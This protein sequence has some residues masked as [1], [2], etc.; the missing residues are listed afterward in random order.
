MLESDAYLEGLLKDR[1]FLLL[2]L[3]R[4]HFF[5]SILNA[6]VYGRGGV[7][8]N[9]VLLSDNGSTLNFVTES[10]AQHAGREKVGTW[11]GTIEQLKDEIQIEA[12]MYQIFFHLTAPF[13]K[14]T[15]VMA[16][17]TSAIGDRVPVDSGVMDVLCELLNIRKEFLAHREDHDDDESP[18]PRG[19][20]TPPA[21]R[22]LALQPPAPSNA[23]TPPAPAAT[24]TSSRMAG[25]SIP[26]S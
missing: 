26:P 14:V 20:R 4:R 21:S 15:S 22:P 9:A 25:K 3:L 1:T 6:M 5:Q 13:N 7:L 18:H 2:P 24:S 17:G 8:E 11:C 16:I 19:P 12:P 23:H 10:F